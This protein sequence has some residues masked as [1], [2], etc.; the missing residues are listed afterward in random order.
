MAVAYESMP[1]AFAPACHSTKPV[2]TDRHA[3]PLPRRARTER[4]DGANCQLNRRFK[5]IASAA[6]PEAEEAKPAAVG[7]LLYVRIS[8]NWP[9]ARK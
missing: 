4:S 6:K 2:N 5:A 9:G 7:M 3:L 8:K 1:S